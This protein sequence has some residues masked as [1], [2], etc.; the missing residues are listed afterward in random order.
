MEKVSTSFHTFPTYKSNF[1]RTNLQRKNLLVKTSSTEPLRKQ[2]FNNWGE[3]ISNQWTE[4]QIWRTSCS[5]V[6]RKHSIKSA[7]KRTRVQQ[8]QDNFVASQMT[9]H[10]NKIWSKV[11]I[12]QYI[13]NIHQGKHRTQI[14]QKPSQSL[15]IHM[16]A[17]SKKCLTWLQ[18]D[19]NSG[20]LCINQSPEE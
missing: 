1:K 4:N 20:G 18:W 2:I 10:K 13:M 7:R 9:G 16:N 19:H 15:G 3:T 12:H 14:D 17:Y 6:R 11:D 8:T 5:A